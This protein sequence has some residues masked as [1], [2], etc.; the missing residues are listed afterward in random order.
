MNKIKITVNLLC[1]VI[2][3]II[4][5]SLIFT[6]G[7]FFRGVHK[8]YSEM[9]EEPVA[10]VT[11]RTHPG[12][13]IDGLPMKTID[14]ESLP[15]RVQML[16]IPVP[17]KYMSTPALV[18][19]LASTLCVV[20]SFIFLMVYFL[21]FI[22]RINRGVIFDTDNMRLLRK[23]GIS[24][25]AISAFGFITN[26]LQQKMAAG[27]ITDVDFCALDIISAIPWT[28][29]V[30]AFVA[31]LMSDVWKGGLVLKNDSELTI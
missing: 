30:I 19:M 17:E 3:A 25:L 12:E 1:A 24:L 29:L 13:S 20:A 31:L 27:V 4:A 21:K 9:S 10:T 28:T 5:V 26:V 7:D 6:V 2:I 11:V 22:I 23:I 15:V 8:G 16:Q 18:V 14:G